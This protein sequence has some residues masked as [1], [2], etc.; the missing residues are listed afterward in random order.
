MYKIFDLQ[1]KFHT[2]CVDMFRSVR[3][4][5]FTCLAHVALYISPSVRK[6]NKSF[7]RPTFDMYIVP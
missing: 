1:T 7:V 5:T 4:P 6:Q 2:P 3:L